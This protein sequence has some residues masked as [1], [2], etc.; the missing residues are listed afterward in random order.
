MLS[1]NLTLDE[2][3]AVQ[4]ELRELQA[5]VV[6]QALLMNLF[7]SISFL[8]QIQESRPEKQI[9]L[10][11]VPTSEPVTIQPDGNV[12]HHLPIRDTSH[13]PLEQEEPEREQNR[14][15]LAA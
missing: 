11:T 9:E 1:N 3:D 12:L 15:P 6:S 8:L 14:V 4:A 2:E 10:P 5:D 13:R 7:C